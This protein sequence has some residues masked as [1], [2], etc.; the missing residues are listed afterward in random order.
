MGLPGLPF[1]PATA[2][3][4]EIIRACLDDLKLSLDGL[5]FS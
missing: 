1:G 2:R 5:K 3:G 4:G